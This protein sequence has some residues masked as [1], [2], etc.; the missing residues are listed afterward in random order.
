MYTPDPTA[1]ELSV[2]GLTPE[3]VATSVEIWPEN[4]RAYELFRSMRTQWRIGMAG[5]TGMDFAVAYRRMDRMRLMPAEYDRL[6]QDLQVMELI[7]LQVM[8]EQA[9]KRAERN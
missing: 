9:E 4:V 1:E 3:D 8:H 5:P 2:A 7:A 6:D